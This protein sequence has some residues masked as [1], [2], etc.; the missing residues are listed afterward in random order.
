MTTP[1][2]P[3]MPG[4]P[5]AQ[6]GAL[7]VLDL[8][9]VVWLAG[10]PI[11]PVGQA[12]DHLRSRRV[13]VVFATNNS[14]PTA[15]ELVTRLE[16]AGV[17]ASAGEIVS[18]AQAVATM[19]APG[20][21]VIVAADA[22]VV[23]ALEA[24]GALVVDDGPADAVVVGWTRR[25]DFDLVARAAAA[26]RNGARFLA[27]N[28]D[29]THPTPDGLLPGTGALV[30]AVATAASATPEVA[31]KPNPPMVSLLATRLAGLEPGS[32][33]VVV[34][35]QMATDGALAAALGVPFALVA[36]GVG[37]GHV[38]PGDDVP[39]AWRAA[40]LVS[41]VAAATVRDAESTE[42]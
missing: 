16:R 40:D 10:T 13:D 37:G 6:P 35:D 7:W 41:L 19:L 8:D 29:P 24:T 30:A 32:P 28:M 12:I 34:G 20:S 42:E 4:A 36:S 22:G 25:F 3:A 39:V 17:P 14:A 9:G 21:T 26:I 15:A 1:D 38:G 27:T 31:G 23:E 5:P 33:A 18:S 11:G 2:G